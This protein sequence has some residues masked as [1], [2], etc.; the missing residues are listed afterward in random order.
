M[1]NFENEHEISK[2]AMMRL[3]ISVYYNYGEDCF[4]EVSAPRIIQL[5]NPFK[6]ST[7]R[8]LGTQPGGRD[9][10]LE[11]DLLGVSATLLPPF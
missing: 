4:Q 3:P 5:F 10:G 7:A 11:F 1:N 2:F 6:Y 9:F 8:R